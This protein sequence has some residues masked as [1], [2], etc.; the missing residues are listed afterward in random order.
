MSENTTT[1]ASAARTYA[2]VVKGVVVEGL[3]TSH[4]VTKL[5]PS[6]M[7]W[8]D[9]TDVVPM[10]APRWTYVG[11]VFTAPVPVPAAAPKLTSLEFMSL[12]T[13]AEQAAIAQAGQGNAMVFLWLLKLAGAMYVDLGDPAT[14]ACV[15][16]L[17]AAGLLTPSRAAAILANQAPVVTPVAAEGVTAPLTG[18]N[19]SY[20]LAQAASPTTAAAS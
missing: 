18:L 19:S 5:F 8:V 6:T 13:S 4:D 20:T 3:S 15:D 2:H 16:A 12:L 10:P 17:A 1:T 11:G 9:I 14:V 7:T